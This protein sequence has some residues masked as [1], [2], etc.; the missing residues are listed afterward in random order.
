MIHPFQNLRL[1]TI[2]G[3]F[4]AC[5][6]GPAP[7][8]LAQYVPPANNRVDLN[9]NYDWKFYK[10]DVTGAQAVGFN[11]SQW[12]AVSLP[13]TW[14]D[15][16]FR[17]WCG[18]TEV[19]PA[20]P[21]RPAGSYFGYAWYRKHF[22]I[23]SAYTG[24]KVI[25]EF[26]GI[27]RAGHFF[28]NG[29]DLGYHENGVGPC[30]LDVTSALNAAGTD[31]VIA[32]QVN[33]DQNYQT[34]EYA[35][36]ATLINPTTGEPYPPTMPYGPPF[37]PNF[38]GLNRDV[39]MHISDTLYQTLP[40]YRNLGT[41]GTYIYPT[42]INTLQQTAGLT[43]NAEV[44]NDG[45]ASKIATLEAVVVDAAGNQVVPTLT[46]AAQTIAPG[47]TAN[48]SGTTSMTDI[49]FWSPDYPYLYQVYTVLRVS[50]NAVDVYKTP[51]GVRKLKFGSTIGLEING[52]PLYLNG[53][54]PR[55]SMEWPAVGVPVDWMNDF[56]F[57]M[58]KAGNA[59]FVRPM[60]I[61]PRKAQVEAADKY[62]ILMTVPAANNEGDDPVP[63]YWNMRMDIMR[64][65]MIY[66]RNNPS[67]IFYEGCNQILTAQ[68]MTDVLNCRLQ[69]DPN[70]GRLAGLRSNDTDVTQGI[71]EYSC[72]MDGAEQ[73]L[74]TPLWDAEYARG[75]SPRRVWDNYTPMLNPRW[76]L[77]TDLGKSTNPAPAPGTI[78]D[79]AH[80]YLLG[81]YFYI[82]S[83]Y[84]QALGLN[85]N[86][87]DAI[88]D[89]LAVIPDGA[90]PTHGYFRLQNSEDMVLENLA[91]YYARYARSV[92]V[93]P[94][95]TSASKGVNVGGAKIIWSDSWTD[96]RMVDTEMAR[97][98]GAVDG[99]RLPKETY[100]GLQ[101]AQNSS[102]DV[103]IVGHWNYP[104]GTVKTVYVVSNTSQV[105][106]QTFDSNGKLIKDYG[107]GTK[108][109]FPAS[110]LPPVGDQVNN[111]VFAFP[112]VAWQAG[113]VTA[114][115][116]NDGSTAAAATHTKATAGAPVA[117]RVTPTV[118]PNGCWY[119]DGSDIAMF[120]VEVVDAAGNR[121]PTYED[122]VTFG[123]SGP[124]TF[125]GGYNSGVRYSTNLGNLTS[126]Y[127]LRIE[128]GIN[129]VFARATRTAGTFTLTVTG[130]GL[131]P[132]SAAVTSTAFTVTNGL[133]SAWPQKDV[134]T[135]EPSSEPAPVAEGTAPPPPANSPNPAPADNVAD[136]HYSGSH[137]DAETLVENVQPGQLAYMDS[138]AITLP[139][140]LPGYLIGG[141]FIRP[142]QSDAGETS[143][144]DQYQLDLTRYSYVYQ[145]IDAA[146][147]M[148]NHENNASYEWT[149]L[150]DTVM[151][152][153]R[154]MNVY[155]SRLMDPYENVYLAVNGYQN[156]APGFNPN[157]N[158]YLLFIVSAEQEL[159]NP[160]DAIA[161]STTQNTG[162][163]A[164]AAIDGD[165]T[166]RWNAA[167]GAM[168]QVLTLTLSDVSSIG[169]YEINWQNGDTH[170]YQY[171]VDVSPDGNTWSKSLDM[172]DNLYTG[173]DEYR[174]PAPLVQNSTGVKYVR[175]T[176]SGATGGAWAAINE[177]KVHGV[178]NKALAPVPVITSALTQAGQAGYAFS[179]QIAATNT[180]TGFAAR[181][182]P[183]GLSINAAGL[184]A[185]TTLQGGTIPITVT[186]INTGG[187]GS[188]VLNV[189]MAAPPPVPVIT[190]ALTYS[191]L[192]GVAIAPAAAYTITAANMNYPAAK[193]N[194]MLPANLGLSD[195]SS[196]GK[197]T[198]TP[199]YPGTYTIPIW[200][201]NPGGAGAPA[202]LQ[203]VVT[204]NGAAPAIT[205]DTPATATAG[206]AYSYQIAASGNPT[207]FGASNLP[208]GLKVST[209]TGLISG[210][211][212]TAGTNS[213]VALSASN[214][215]G[216]GSKTVTI[217]VAANPVVPA[218]TSALTE[219]GSA[220]TVFS[221]QITATNTP[222][223]YSATPLPAGLSVNASG[224]IA[225]TPTAPG[226]TNVTLKATNASGVSAP[227]T[228]VVTIGAKVA[229]P[230]VTAPL[231]LGGEVN[232]AFTYQIGA[233][234]SPTSYSATPL[235][236][237]L[238]VDAATGAISGTPTAAAT[239]TT[240]LSAVNAG[241]T[242]ATRSVILT[243]SA[244]GADV[245]LALNQP[246][247]PSSTPRGSNIAAN[248][249]DGSASTRWESPWDDTETIYVD[250]GATRTIHGVVFNW[251]TACARD[252]RIEVTNDPSSESNWTLACPEI[253]NGTAG[254]YSF[255]FN[256]AIQARYVRM[257]GILRG[258]GYGYSLYEF[259]VMGV[260]P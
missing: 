44:K 144:T 164:S 55:C 208:P 151:V 229:V 36:Q 12:A 250:L 2:V 97:V 228:L 171:E 241:G 9:F 212:T 163:P 160:A 232:K 191:T 11:D 49:H 243:V 133:A 205:S 214:A 53:Y 72:T 83:D 87:A 33:N 140:N 60:H 254:T 256:A 111:Y 147:G 15:D 154:P 200:G 145:L 43:V 78:G 188:A 71:R 143:S 54:A 109:F 226:T 192:A 20:D 165:V 259:Q 156:V 19:P 210:T 84:H 142:F 224:L 178:F 219:A 155:K 121:C 65:V 108:N 245:N 218:I 90:N 139:A 238:K 189:T 149:K 86:Q 98:S 177:F 120:D 73:N 242:S 152:N 85:T 181:G 172:T 237:G 148:P 174:V 81:G 6:T 249:V 141:E 93:Q 127:N 29:T 128:A 167:S 240:V 225:G 58:M 125:L 209:S 236:A 68:H 235:P 35:P 89:Y 112:N 117:L 170:A 91:K 38:G 168:P 146:N 63:M 252:Y 27:G 40:L 198:G 119:A 114:T 101:V 106:L 182:L 258:T 244:T 3:F 197:I 247:T 123:C 48:F 255:P 129:R 257:H 124:G 248:A 59:N 61:A 260:A 223:S 94:E 227:A 7:V 251:E 77:S 5:G 42:N 253:T 17:E 26:Q 169:G 118:G 137:S 18:I 56:D 134:I 34:H 157:S 153:G 105:K 135:L 96:A 173:A 37:N 130:S 95:A 13:H 23:D 4:V 45:I 62:G 50:G 47:A 193:Y 115:A 180:P 203:F 126:G 166:T 233:T 234:N 103:Y 230:V 67:V 75:E 158:M 190:S 183:A 185:G 57:A 110:I 159:Q 64:D 66:Y 207:L 82:A 150:A 31:N 222:T 14:N 41:V 213:T 100:Y 201:S 99:V 10:A 104:A 74:T 28:V 116:Y 30:G 186:A 211:P 113:S 22:T 195:S 138:N 8:A 196:T 187:A 194:A 32:V 184:I 39:T 21:L 161:A 246:V 204:A 239:T 69:W 199:K 46:M 216:T 136:L 206:T 70:G 179:Y 217:T 16:E 231:N 220:G 102:P 1:L 132:A 122:T 79:A 88:A 107:Y 202:N 215:G 76:A 131:A 92:F 221:Y 24:R 25:L 51:L 52:H 80:K 175:L 162:T 176:I